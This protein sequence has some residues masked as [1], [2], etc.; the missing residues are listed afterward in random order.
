[1][2]GNS[3][4]AQRHEEQRPQ[5]QGTKTKHNDQLKDTKNTK[6][7]KIHK[8]KEYFENLQPEPD[9]KTE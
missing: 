4:S 2:P 6:T 7:S 3:L 9:N 5:R 1:M 8:R